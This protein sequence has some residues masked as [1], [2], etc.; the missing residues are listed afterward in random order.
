MCATRT[1]LVT[2]IDRAKEGVGGEA[3]NEIEEKEHR[4]THKHKLSA[5]IQPCLKSFRLNYLIQE[6]MYSLFALKPVDLDL[7]TKSYN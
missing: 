5:C 7:V 3:S 1:R 4:E 6:S 2:F